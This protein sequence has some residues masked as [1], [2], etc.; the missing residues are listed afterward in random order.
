M[1]AYVPE[2]GDIVWMQFNPQV[3]REQAG[4]RPAL[5]LSPKAYNQKTSL[6]LC[7]PITSQVKGYPFEVLVQTKSVSGAIL[8][9][10][11]KSLDWKARYAKKKGTVSVEIIDEVISKIDAL[12]K[13]AAK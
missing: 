9:N 10:Q 5:V 8:S 13:G 6:M 3:G 7:C 2:R 12:L 11:V 4:M 1:A